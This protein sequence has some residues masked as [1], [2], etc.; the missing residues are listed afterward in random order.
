MGGLLQPVGDEILH[1]GHAQHPA[2][3]GQAGIAADIGRPGHLVQGEL[4][5]KVGLEKDHHLLGPD[6]VGALPGGQVVAGQLLG[7]LGHGLPHL[8]QQAVDV[9]LVGAG[10]R[11]AQVIGLAQSV[12][13]V[14]L[15]GHLWGED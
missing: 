12:Q 1:G 2:E 6:L 4:F 10:L 8:A 9:Q 7:V 14:P 5:P 13:A 3:T 15:P 11:L